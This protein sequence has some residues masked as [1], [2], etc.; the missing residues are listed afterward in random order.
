MDRIRCASEDS[1][2]TRRSC[3]WRTRSDR[4]VSDLLAK[5]SPGGWRETLLPARYPQSARSAVR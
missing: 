5:Q 3:G 4:L 2:W 1:D